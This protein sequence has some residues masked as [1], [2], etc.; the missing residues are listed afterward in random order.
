MEDSR[1]DLCDLVMTTALQAVCC[2]LA[3]L[4]EAEE[5]CHLERVAQ[6]SYLTEQLRKTK[7]E[8]NT[9]KAQLNNTGAL[10][11]KLQKEHAQLKGKIS[12]FEGSIDQLSTALR[13]VA[14]SIPDN[15]IRNILRAAGDQRWEQCSAEERQDPPPPP[16]PPPPSAVRKA[17]GGTASAPPAAAPQPV[18]SPP[19]PPEGI[20]AAHTPTHKRR[21]GVTVKVSGSSHVVPGSGPGR[22]ERD[23]TGQSRRSSFVGNT[24]C[25]RMP[26]TCGLPRATCCC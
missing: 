8:L 24:S 10:Y 17:A 22:S 1:A 3:Y 12:E 25:G 7:E 13:I 15:R 21:A 6:H 18:T 4:A 19:A 20:S 2:T 23:T 14:S 5:K 9:T 26:T 16:P 11:Q